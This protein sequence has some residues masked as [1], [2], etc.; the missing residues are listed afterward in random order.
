M[1]MSEEYNITKASAS[2]YRIQPYSK[3]NAMYLVAYGWDKFKI[4]T[5]R[6]FTTKEGA[7]NYCRAILNKEC[8]VRGEEISKYMQ[9]CVKVYELYSDKPPLKIKYEDL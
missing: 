7:K 3:G 6:I 2:W 5:M 1:D 9:Y 8:L 4:S